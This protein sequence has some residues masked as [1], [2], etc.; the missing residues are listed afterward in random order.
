MSAVDPAILS[1][2][3]NIPQAA[4]QARRRVNAQSANHMRCLHT[5]SAPTEA[6]PG[7]LPEPSGDRI[8]PKGGGYGHISS[9]N[10]ASIPLPIRSH[11]DPSCSL[12]PRPADQR[13]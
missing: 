9:K 4:D 12:F 5:H 1:T 2:T 10:P 13:D 6:N 8:G 11:F 3:L 7:D